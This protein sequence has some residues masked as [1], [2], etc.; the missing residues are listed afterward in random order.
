MVKGIEVVE[1]STILS[2]AIRAG[3]SE[4]VKLDQRPEGREGVSPVDP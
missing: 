3:F 4:E 1:G 2:R